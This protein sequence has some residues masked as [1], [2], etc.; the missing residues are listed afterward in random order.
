MEAERHYTKWET[1]SE[2]CWG[3]IGDVLVGSKGKKSEMMQRISI[4]CLLQ[5]CQR[6]NCEGH[7]MSIPLKE[8]C[9][10]AVKPGGRCAYAALLAAKKRLQR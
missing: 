7:L 4:I 6:H 1:W 5:N 8:I 2:S 3:R 10:F 9:E